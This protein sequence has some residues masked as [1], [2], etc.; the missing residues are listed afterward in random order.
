MYVM[1]VLI[2]LCASP[3][4]DG[5]SARQLRTWRIFLVMVYVTLLTTYVGT[6]A[7]HPLL[8]WPTHRALASLD[9][10]HADIPRRQRHARLCFQYLFRQQV[11]QRRF[12][13]R[14]V[15]AV[16]VGRVRRFEREDLVCPYEDGE[17]GD[18]FDFGKLATDAG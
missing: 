14:F 15:G 5:R 9:Q 4:R 3:P 17:H 1:T 11:R 12:M 7:L 8:L 13:C 18:H 16:N 2:P 6:F 10:P